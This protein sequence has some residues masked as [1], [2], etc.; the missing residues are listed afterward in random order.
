YTPSF[1]YRQVCKPN[2][3]ANI[4]IFADTG[5]KKG[6]NMRCQRCVNTI[7]VH[8]VSGTACNIKTVLSPLVLQRSS[9]NLLPFSCL[10]QK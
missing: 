9:K 4:H 10:F 5:K 1:I 8:R 3:A 6:K 2:S 7:C